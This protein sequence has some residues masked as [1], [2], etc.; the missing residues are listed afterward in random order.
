VLR[1]SEIPPIYSDPTADPIES[2]MNTLTTT[3]PGKLSD[4]FQLKVPIAFVLA[5]DNNLSEQGR[6]A[7]Q[8]LAE[9]ITDLP[10]DLVVEVE[11]T[12]RLAQACRVTQFMFQGC[13]IHP[14]RLAVGV[15]PGQHTSEGVFWLVLVRNR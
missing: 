12:S 4:N 6:H 15:R 3:P 13:G 8:N 7:L 11:D 5:E 10:Y 2:V 1:G 9:A 14:S